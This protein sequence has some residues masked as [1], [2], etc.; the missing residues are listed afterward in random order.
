MHQAVLHQQPSRSGFSFQWGDMSAILARFLRDTVS[1]QA[2]TGATPKGTVTYSAVK[3]ISCSKSVSSKVVLDSS[4]GE[5]FMPA[6]VVWAYEQCIKHGDKIDGK[7]VRRI[8]KSTE[9]RGP[10][11]VVYYAN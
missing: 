1:H 8:E 10:V 9:S 5:Q 7:T 2:R 11:S 3:V 4:T 6:L